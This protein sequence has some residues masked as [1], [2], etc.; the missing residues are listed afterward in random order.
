MQIKIEANS[1]TLGSLKPGERYELTIRSASSPERVSSTAAIVEITMPR[2]TCHCTVMDI[3][4][5]SAI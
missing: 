2:G 4:T 5:L 1:F 3:W